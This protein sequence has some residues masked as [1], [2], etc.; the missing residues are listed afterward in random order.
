MSEYEKMENLPNV[1]EEG[2]G[3][4][5]DI[6]ERVIFSALR[7]SRALKR[8][9]PDLGELPF[10]PAVGSVLDCVRKNS[11]VSSRELCELLDLRPSSLSE[12]LARAE[13]DG[14]LARV[15]DEEDKRMQHIAL[16][17]KGESLVAGIENARTQDAVQKTACFTEE[18]KKIFCELC[19]RL[20]A[21]LEKLALDL[22]EYRE[23]QGGPREEA[24]GGA[25][26]GGPRDG[27]FPG[28]PGGEPE[29]RGPRGIFRKKPPRPEREE[30]E[31]QTRPFPPDA[32]FRC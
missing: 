26:H 7:V 10:P 2:S 31:G 1:Q 25:P 13:K 12:I 28:G 4:R 18:E 3:D 23:P 14:L 17:E 5:N 11:G 30:K 9:P 27:R 8:C 20:S 29:R 15:P 19:D 6:N 16:T 21:H 32:R 24:F 22:P